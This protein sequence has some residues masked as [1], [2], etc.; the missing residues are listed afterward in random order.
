MKKQLSEKERLLEDE[1]QAHLALQ[2]KVKDIR[3][4][5]NNEKLKVSKMVR[6][7]DDILLTKRQE[8]QSLSTHCHSQSQLISKVDNILFFLITKNYQFNTSL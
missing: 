1:Q 2:T 4:E 6:D 5:L 8:L 3:I 7:H